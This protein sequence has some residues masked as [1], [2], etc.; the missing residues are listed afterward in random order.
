ML[1]RGHCQEKQQHHREMEPERD[2]KKKKILTQE[3][4]SGK[5]RREERKPSFQVCLKLVLLNRL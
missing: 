4:R 3:G 2:G 1:K 5:I